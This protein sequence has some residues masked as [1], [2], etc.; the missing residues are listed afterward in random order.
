MNLEMAIEMTD[1][2]VTFL[3][4]VQTK[5]N[6]P[7]ATVRADEYHC[8]IAVN[9]PALRKGEHYRGIIISIRSIITATASYQHTRQEK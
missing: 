3:F 4:P 8:T 9:L 2:K 5:M 7:A 6:V 1:K